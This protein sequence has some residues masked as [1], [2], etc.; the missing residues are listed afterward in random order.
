[1]KIEK[2]RFGLYYG[3]FV[4]LTY[5]L[6]GLYVDSVGVEDDYYRNKTIYTGILTLC[7]HMI[8]ASLYAFYSL[9]DAFWGKGEDEDEYDSLTH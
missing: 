8:I 5:I 1:M 4:L 6:V 3:A 7:I 2:D 9:Y